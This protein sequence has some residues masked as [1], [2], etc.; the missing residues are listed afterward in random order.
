M[1]VA[2]AASLRI[3]AVVYP[4]WYL[5]VVYPKL[6]VAVRTDCTD[7]TFA[8]LPLVVVV[9]PV[10]E[11][12]AAVSVARQPSIRLLLQYHQIP[13][14]LVD[15]QFLFRQF[16]AV[17]LCEE[18]VEVAALAAVVAAVEDRLVDSGLLEEADDSRPVS[19]HFQTNFPDQ[20]R[21][22]LLAVPADLGM[23]TGRRILSAAD[24]VPNVETSFLDSG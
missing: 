9:A 17:D 22:Q 16:S 4:T 18:A 21:L 19:R 3:V 13:L 20:A 7:P 2:V 10:G 8:L 5:V 15:L 1:A 11:A 23:H 6:Q 12:V 24:L 14:L